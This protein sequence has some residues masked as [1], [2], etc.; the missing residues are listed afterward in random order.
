MVDD[1]VPQW[2]TLYLTPLTNFSE[3]QRSSRGSR[4]S[5]KLEFSNPDRKLL[6]ARVISKK[7]IA[8]AFFEGHLPTNPMLSALHTLKV[9]NPIYTFT[10]I[11]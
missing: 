2:R 6:P 3:C 7:V 1:L 8:L 9:Q 11:E 4:P 5:R 10:F